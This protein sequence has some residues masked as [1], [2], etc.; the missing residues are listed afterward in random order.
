MESLVKKMFVDTGGNFDNPT[1]ED[2]IKACNALAEFAQNFRKPSFI[3]K[4][5]NKIMKLIN[6]LD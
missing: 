2:L 1:K 6:N 5:Y 4:R 3:K